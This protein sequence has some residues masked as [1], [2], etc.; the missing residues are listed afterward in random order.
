MKWLEEIRSVELTEI[1]KPEDWPAV[2]AEERTKAMAANLAQTD[3]PINLPVLNAATM[4][5]VAGKHRIGGCE[6]AGRPRVQVRM[7]TCSK[8]QER[9]LRASDNAFPRD[10]Y[11]AWVHELVEARAAV[12]EEEKAQG[13]TPDKLSGVTGPAPSSRGEARRDV[14]GLLG[15]SPEA[16]RK[17]D[18]RGDPDR[19]ARVPPPDGKLRVLDDKNRR[20]NPD[21][22]K[23]EAQGTLDPFE[24]DGEGEETADEPAAPAEPKRPDFMVRLRAFLPKHNSGSPECPLNE[25]LIA[26]KDAENWAKRWA[27]TKD[28]H[29]RTTAAAQ[30]FANAQDAG[31]LLPRVWDRCS[32]VVRLLGIIKAQTYGPQK[33]NPVTE[34]P[35]TG[36][37]G[38]A[39]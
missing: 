34:G 11:D 5:I 9:F 27:G 28:E 39:L 6:L 30:V 8:A 1:R 16:I 4:E 38:R 31:E 2:L 19:R 26:L 36:L 24:E 33:H 29:G 3:G 14:A 25:L 15:K 17:A 37:G 12:I 22:E 23:F 32:E 35:K 7:V 20:F 18:E 10:D 21:T 13:R